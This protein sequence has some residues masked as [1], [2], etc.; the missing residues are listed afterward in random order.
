MSGKYKGVQAEIKKRNKLAHYV[1]CAAHSLNIVGESSVDEC[2]EAT[3]FFGYLQKLY[4]FFVAST[5]RWE[6]LIENI[7]KKNEEIGTH[8]AVLVVKSLS[9]TRWSCRE[10]AVKSLVSNYDGIFNALKQLAENP[11]E[12]KDTKDE[13]FSLKKKMIRLE[14]AFMAIFW[15]QVLERF[16]ATSK[17]LQ[18]PGLDVITGHTMLVSLLQFVCDFRGQ[19]E[20][21]E[22]K[23]KAMSSIL[24]TSYQDG[25]QRRGIKKLADGST[26]IP[27]QGSDK[28]RIESYLPM[29]DK[30]ISELEKR[31]KAYKEVSDIF[32]FF[33]RLSILSS[34]EIITKARNLILQYSDD[35]EDNLV[36][37]LLQF[38]AFLKTLNLNNESSSSVPFLLNLLIE[39]DLL[40]VFPEIFIALRIYLCIPITNC[41]TERSF[42]KLSFIKNKY[43]TTMGEARLAHLAL[44]SIEN[45]LLSSLNF[46]D[47]IEDF[48]T[49]KARKKAL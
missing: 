41:E 35:L 43:R 42:S 44:M 5:H 17:Y 34:E 33:S 24:N 25:Y 13:A 32:G 39:R 4:A 14:N 45:E 18:K 8:R 49:L 47:I 37:E 22:E 15:N 21:L 30:I 31:N 38:S 46:D 11:L 36:Q 1:P 23:A 29:I 27:R 19:F 28:F 40:E 3:S 6:I 26:E 48:S 10:Q 9:A 20:S 12:K 7:N 16:D 2:V